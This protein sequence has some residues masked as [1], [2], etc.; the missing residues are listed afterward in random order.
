MAKLSAT[1]KLQSKGQSSAALCV[2]TAAYGTSSSHKQA[3]LDQGL[4][5]GQ[6]SS[7]SFSRAADRQLR[8]H[9]WR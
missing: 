3:S 9:V 5:V 8:L 6:V 1:C 4:S 7:T 2:G